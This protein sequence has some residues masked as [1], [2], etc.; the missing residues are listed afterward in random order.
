[1]HGYKK[2]VYAYQLTTPK[3]LTFKSESVLPA[4]SD[5]YNLL[6]EVLMLG[7]GYTYLRA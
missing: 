5:I 6:H 1:M 3:S 4:N 2:K 7:R